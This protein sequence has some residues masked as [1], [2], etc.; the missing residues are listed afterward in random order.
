MSALKLR[1][2]Q[3]EPKEFKYKIG[4]RLRDIVTG[5]EGVVVA[6]T[7]Y[8]TGCNR[9]SLQNQELDKD[10]KP[11]DWQAFDEN[12]LD[13]VKDKDIAIKSVRERGGPAPS[14]Q[15]SMPTDK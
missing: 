13:E 8:L 3:L 7:Q 9:Y 12:Q 14:A 15:Y 6:R 5:F 10:G 4:A 2:K 11:K 1:G